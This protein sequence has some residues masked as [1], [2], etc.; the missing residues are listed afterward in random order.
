M[1]LSSQLLVHFDSSKELI[2]CC[3]ASAYGIGAVLAHRTSNGTEQPI[4]FVS[5]TLTKAERNYSQIE[6]EALSCIFGIKRFHTYLY[7]HRFT[8]ITDHKPL[9]SLFKE[10]KAIPQQASGWIQRWALTLAGYEYIIS[11]RPIES[12]SNA[13]ALSRLP[14][15]IP[16]ESVPAVPETVLLLEQLD[17]GPFTAQQVK[18]FTA[19]DPCLSQVLT[20][21]Q[22]GWPNNVSEDHMKPYWRRRNE[23][24]VQSGCI[25]WGCRVIVPPQGR[26]IV[27]QELHRGHPGM[28]RMKSLARG[29][30][31][32][33]KLDDEI[34]TMVCSCSVCQTQGDSPP[35]APLIPWQWL[36][37]PWKRLHIDYAGPFMGHMWLVIIDAHTKWLEVFQMSSTSSSTTIQCLREVFTRFGIPERIVTDN[38]TNFTSAEFSYFLKQ[39]G[40]KQTTSAP[41][42]PASNGLAERA[43]KI[44]KT[45]IKKM[46]EGSL[47]Q[48]LSRFLFSYRRTPQ[49]TIGVSPAELSMNRK[50]RSVLDL[51]NPSL[52]N[53]VK[54]SQSAQKV[55][56]DKRAKPRIFACGDT[57]YVRNYGQ[58]PAWIKGTIVDTAGPLFK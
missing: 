38:A 15:Q 41:Y 39:N 21:V 16:E 18:Y 44:F 42:H 9:L 8:L 17:D 35:A 31:W 49:S 34:E 53:K 46:T 37:R 14:V 13:D 29:I 51:L 24:S 47:K 58:G 27:L 12:H 3:D 32:W 57:V 40:I 54:S 43:V 56:H 10:N 52:T 45:G 11:F 5:R 25:L 7:G 33:P 19:R 26:T 23:L 22:K 4:G 50:L 6:K 28:T 55:S 30:V 1:L 2:L 36:S 48:K 20:F